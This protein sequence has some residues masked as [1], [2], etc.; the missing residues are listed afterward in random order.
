VTASSAETAADPDEFREYIPGL[1]NGGEVAFTFTVLEG[2]ETTHG[3][4]EAFADAAR[5]HAAAQAEARRLHDAGE[6]H[7]ADTCPHCTAE[8]VAKALRDLAN[9]LADTL[10][11]MLDAFR[12]AMEETPRPK[13]GPP[14]ALQRAP[15]EHASNTGLAARSRARTQSQ[16]NA[17]RR[18]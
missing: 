15:R 5:T 17:L 6:P 2:P 11:P 13:N 3:A 9:A 18:L 14:Q 4:L 1:K 16:R 8:A 10:T 7:H 12:K